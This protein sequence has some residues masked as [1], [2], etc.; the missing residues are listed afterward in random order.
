MREVFEQSSSARI[1]AEL[2]DFVPRNLADHL[3]RHAKVPANLLDE[4][5]PR[6]MRAAYFDDRFHRQ[7]SNL[8]PQGNWRLVDPAAWGPDWMKIA[9]TARYLFHQKSQ[10]AIAGGSAAKPAKIKKD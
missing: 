7:H 3:P 4:L 2:R 1:L 10:A 5:A 9:P 6:N 8:I